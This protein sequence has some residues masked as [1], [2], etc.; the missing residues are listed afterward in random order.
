MNA[1]AGRNKL[2]LYL[3]F[4]GVLHHQNVLWHSLI[5]P[6]LSAPDGY[7]LFQH[8]TL[9]EHI[10]EP[11][12]EVSIV[13]STSWVLR[14]SLAKATKNLKPSLRYRVIGATYNSR[15]DEQSFIAMP[16][17][18]QVQQDVLRRQPKAW[19]AVDDDDFGWPTDCLG[20]LVVTHKH[21]GISAPDVLETFKTKLREMCP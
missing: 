3:D 11:Y 12:P 1:L 19:L 18:V 15:R 5:G 17:G 21:A 2:L 14:F 8:A 7:V 4:D 16:R 9:L 13:L 10:L 6:Y 20:H